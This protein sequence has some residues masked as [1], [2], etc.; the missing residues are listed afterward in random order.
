LAAYQRRSES[1][2][3]RLDDEGLLEAIAKARDAG[4]LDGARRVAGMLAW[5]Y[6]DRV[7]AKVRLR[8]PRR[9]VEDVAMNVMES[10]VRS[11]FDGKYLG[12]FGAWINTIV[13]RRIADYHR[14]G[15]QL[16]DLEPLPD[17]HQGDE[18]VWVRAPAAEDELALLGYR[19][20][21]E[22]IRCSRPNEVHRTVIAL[23]GLGELGY[24]D[25]SAAA[26]RA[27]VQRLHPGETVSEAN[28]HQIWKRFK[29]DLAEALLRSDEV[30]R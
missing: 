2:L 5:R 13:K 17:E 8:T 6:S 12:E 14:K 7:R 15:E 27:E 22:Q 20:I 30:D 29:E 16:P 24:Q 19:E 4:D 23:Y 25:L 21:A 18:D 9:D 3:V 11:A 1:E 26:T 28:I 10:A